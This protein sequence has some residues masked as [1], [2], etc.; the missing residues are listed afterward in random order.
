MRTVAAAVLLALT[1]LVARPSWA[2]DAVA[3]A[4]PPAAP[5]PPAIAPLQPY[6]APPPPA[7]P[8][9]ALP[10]AVQAADSEPPQSAAV[11]QL[12]TE[13]TRVAEPSE[14][15][16]IFLETLLA[17]PAFFAAF[18]VAART[19]PW[20][21][22]A[23][24]IVPGGIV[25]AVGHASD[26]YDGSCGGAIGGAYAGT[27][28]ALPLALLFSAGD[29]GSG[30]QWIPMWVVGAA[31]G[32]V[33]G[34]PIGAVIGWNVSREPKAQAHAGAARLDA[35]AAARAAPWREPLLARGS[36]REGAGP[37]AATLPVLAF[38]F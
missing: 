33:F 4:P 2:A 29:S 36:L 22:L 7:P 28:L 27:L 8:P 24:P 16:L 26:Y 9:P 23:T 3:P 5:A 32:L 37:H 1:A 6:D 14:A 13:P 12:A 15:G 10:P 20:L 25:C 19:T 34:P 31:L 35:L 38:R 21:L 18:A 30:D 11:P 17:F